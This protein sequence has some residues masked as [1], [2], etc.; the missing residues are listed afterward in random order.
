MFIKYVSFFHSR[1]E[2]ICGFLVGREA[3]L[4]FSKRFLKYSRKVIVRATIV[5]QTTTPFRYL[6]VYLTAK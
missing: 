5:H 1:N 6:I 3:Y 4:M 2:N